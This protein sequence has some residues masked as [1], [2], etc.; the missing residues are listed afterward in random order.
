MT[1]V[2]GAVAQ[3][4]LYNGGPIRE[5]HERAHQLVGLVLTTGKVTVETRVWQQ[6]REV[7]NLRDVWNILTDWGQKGTTTLGP[8]RSLLPEDWTMLCFYSAGPL[9]ELAINGTALVG[10]YCLSSGALVGFGVSGLS[11]QLWRV[12]NAQYNLSCCDYA[13][14]AGCFSRLISIAK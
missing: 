14:I 4:I 11:T 3:V 5:L 9:V 8:G 10:A 1:F 2:A 7:A 6:W 12:W 13:A